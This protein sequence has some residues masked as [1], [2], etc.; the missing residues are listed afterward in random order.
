[1]PDQPTRR[2]VH[3]GGAGSTTRRE[4]LGEVVV[5]AAVGAAGVPQVFAEAAAPKPPSRSKV[6]EV[7]NPAWQKGRRVNAAVVQQMVENALMKLTGKSS[8]ADAWRQFVSPTERVGVKF[9][10]ITRNISKANQ[11][12]GD[13]ILGGL[14]QAGVKRENIIVVEA[15]GAKFPGTGRYDGTYGPEVHTP[16]GTT[17]HTRFI[18]EQVD[19]VINVPDLKEH[20]R[21]GVTLSLKNLS[22]G[23]SIMHEPWKFHSGC[24]SPHIGELHALKPIAGK[25][26]LN[27]LNGL[28]GIFHLGP[29]PRGRRWQWDRNS[30]FVS[31][32]PVAL[33]AICLDIIQEKRR[34]SPEGIPIVDLFKTRRRPVHIADAAQIGLGTADR[35]RID[36]VRVAQG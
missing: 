19:V 8:G 27:I 3:T 21:A 34:V 5:G 25:R 2:R 13:A 14:M 9:N 18:R 10:K 1:M 29:M 11:A 26:R 24:C 16:H 4:F 33:D 30:L 28:R 17:R 12:L 6:V 20:D 31:T 22:H 32:D 36:W 7:T 15:V 23:A 35:H